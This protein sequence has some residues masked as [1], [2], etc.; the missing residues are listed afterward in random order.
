MFAVDT[1]G[2]RQAISQGFPYSG[3][4]YLRSLFPLQHHSSHF[5]CCLASRENTSSNF[6]RLLLSLGRDSKR[7]LPRTSADEIFLQVRNPTRR[8]RTAKGEADIKN[9]LDSFSVDYV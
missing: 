9:V 2:D 3:M 6:T 7:A 5:L 8:K 1:P 4:E